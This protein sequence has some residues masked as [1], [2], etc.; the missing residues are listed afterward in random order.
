MCC[1]LLVV[2][3]SRDRKA[4]PACVVRRQQQQQ[5]LWRVNMVGFVHIKACN[6]GLPRLAYIPKVAACVA[7][8]HDRVCAHESL[9][10]WFATV[11]Q[12]PESNC[13]CLA[14]DG[15]LQQWFAT[16]CRQPES[17]C[18]CLAIGESLQHIWQ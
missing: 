7:Y 14:T 3:G 13:G 4:Q 16:V 9:Q 6:N 5:H 10:Q 11:C 1:F 17:K 12:Q 18:G 15:S 2:L 8:V